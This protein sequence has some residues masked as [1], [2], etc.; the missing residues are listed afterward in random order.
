MIKLPSKFRNTSILL[1]VLD[2]NI[3]LSKTIK[4]LLRDN[5]HSIKNIFLIVDKKKT[6]IKSQNLCHSFSKKFKVIKIVYQ[7]TPKLGGAFRDA[8]KHIRSSHCVIMCSDLETDPN[9]VK[10]LISTSKKNPK[11]IIQASRWIG[12][13]NFYNYGIIKVF[14]NFIFQK[15]FSYLFNVNCSDLTFGFRIL[16]TIIV[17]SFKWEMNDHSFVFE[18]NLRP[19]LSGVGIKTIKTKWK[20]RIE[21]E[22]HN[23]IMN[24]YKYLFIGSLY[25]LVTHH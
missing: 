22:G 6:I 19:I 13:N 3:S 18:S 9:T 10:K 21:G 12:K 7:K 25:M 14:M 4:I 1:P 16:P 8:I 23:Q 15:V 5:A 2:E 11:K 24:Y 20:K 17:R